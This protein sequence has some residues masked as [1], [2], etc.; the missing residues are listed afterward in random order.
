MRTVP[1]LHASEGGGAMKKIRLGNKGFSLLELLIGITMLAI[2]VVPILHA[3][4]TS[5]KT[6]VKA[7]E[8]RNETLAAQNILESYEATEIGTIIQNIKKH[9]MPFGDIASSAQ[10]FIDTGSNNFSEITSS[11]TEVKD[12]P[13]YKICLKNVA[14]GDKTYDAVLKIDASKYTN[15]NSVGIVDYKPMDAVYIQPDNDG[16]PDVSAAKE[17][18]SLAR[19]DS[20]CTYI[21]SQGIA[22]NVGGTVIDENYF[23]GMMSRTITIYIQKIGEDTGIISCKALFKYDTHFSYTLIDDSTE[24]PTVTTH[25]IIYPSITIPNDFYSGP[26]TESENG[27]NGLYFF[28]YPNFFEDTIDIENRGNINMSV[29]LIKQ[30]A[31]GSY[32]PDI[33]LREREPLTKPHAQMYYNSDDDTYNYYIGYLN[34]SGGFNDYH[35]KKFQFNGDL[36]GTPAQNRLYG[37]TVDLYS[38]GSINESGGV[39][40]EP[41]LS[42]DA[43]SLE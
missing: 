34:S 10:V 27:I 18:A 37:V 43:S 9:V 42:F 23:L 2:I 28:F 26:Y 31:A 35:Y 14:A 38:A 41:I 4:L 17:F 15:R 22:N 24:P 12:G 21:D 13:A 33:N 39:S 20:G 36:V 29:Y 30:D 16:N 1:L 8:M 6:S 11:S 7:K 19:I 25:D 40:G 32:K 5:S 3:F